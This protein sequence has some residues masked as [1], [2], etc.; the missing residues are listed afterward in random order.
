MIV[1]IG[2]K[3]HAQRASASCALKLVIRI[4]ATLESSKRSR[5]LVST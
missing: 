2:V 4:D 5:K 1:N 3:L